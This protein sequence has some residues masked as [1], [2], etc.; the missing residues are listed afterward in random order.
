MKVYVQ[1]DLGFVTSVTLQ[2]DNDPPPPNS[3]D[4]TGIAVRPQVGWTQLAGEFVPTTSNNV[5]RA[6]L[7]SRLTPAEL[8]AWYRA[9]ER[10][11]LTNTPVVADR[12]ALYAQVRFEA[13]PMTVDLTS[14]DITGLKSVWVAL[15]MTQARADALLTPA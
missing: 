1:T 8:H 9:S 12:N 3:I 13:L 6:S 7:L 10:A 14:A 11:R 4:V 15:G 2:D 5:T